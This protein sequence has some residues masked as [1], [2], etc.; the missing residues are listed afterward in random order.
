MSFLP[1]LDSLKATGTTNLDF[2]KQLGNDMLATR[3][4]KGTEFYE[5]LKSIAIR[6]FSLLACAYVLYLPVQMLGASL[7]A[8]LFLAPAL[9]AGGTAIIL[10][11]QTALA[12]ES[13]KQKKGDQHEFKQS[14]IIDSV[15]SAI[16][17]FFKP[18]SN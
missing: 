12:S 6:A 2:I 8:S 14:C 5:K 17:D 4:L 1:S 16:W 11:A 10:L 3:D 18:V 9:L 13:I 7:G 15:R